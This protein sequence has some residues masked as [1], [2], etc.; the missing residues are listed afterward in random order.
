[1]EHFFLNSVDHGEPRVIYPREGRMLCR[2]RHRCHSFRIQ[3][4]ETVPRLTDVLALDATRGR[5]CLCQC[6]EHF[7]SHRET[8]I[9]GMNMCRATC[10]H[11]AVDGA[12][13]NHGECDHIHEL[14]GVEW[15][16]SRATL[17]RSSTAKFDAVGC[18]R[19]CDCLSLSETD[20]GFFCPVIVVF[21]QRC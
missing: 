10:V 18:H 7:H 4:A 16:V 13:G 15:S 3:S 17:K 5:L 21:R 2:R 20:L 9:D 11:L 1:M 6:R 19:S 14:K 8:E 12:G